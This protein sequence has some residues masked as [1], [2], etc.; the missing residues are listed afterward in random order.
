MYVSAMK[1]KPTLDAES[2]GA[3][4]KPELSISTTNI[5]GIPIAP[6][7]A[8]NQYGEVMI[9]KQ[10]VDDARME[11]L[12]RYLSRCSGGRIGAVRCPCTGRQVRDGLAWGTISLAIEIGALLRKA[13]SRMVERLVQALDGKLR[14]TGK[15]QS[16]EHEK[17]AAFFWGM[18][19]LEG[20]G[21]FI[22][23][24][25]KICYK[26]ENLVSWHNDTLDV[27]CPDS[28]MV[29]D[30]KSGEGLLNQPPFFPA[31]REVAVIARR[32]HE[33]W[34]K[35]RGLALFGPEH[36]GF[37]FAYRSFMEK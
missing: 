19:H 37:S 25:Y 31:G 29:V 8:V 18:I 27:T 30:G 7:A 10:A 13:G 24:R 33:L 14:F 11:V 26:N 20:T 22:G 34:R 3:R 28:I 36:F 2:A 15:V 35:E 16:F 32:A 12:T 5:L 6:L 21:S 23:Q 1:G 4:A 9:V 17:R